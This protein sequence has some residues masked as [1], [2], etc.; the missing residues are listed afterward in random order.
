MCVMFKPDW[1][2]VNMKGKGNKTDK[3]DH[4]VPDAEAAG[5][6]FVFSKYYLSQE[7]TEIMAK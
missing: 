1:V 4:L 6:S 2:Y 3:T 7:S 5:G